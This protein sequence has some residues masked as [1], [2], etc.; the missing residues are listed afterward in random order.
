M[1]FD[2]EEIKFSRN[3]PDDTPPDG[4]TDCT[5]MNNTLLQLVE[6][7][8]AVDCSIPN[9]EIEFC[10]AVSNI[11]YQD[12]SQ[13]TEDNAIALLVAQVFVISTVLKAFDEE[14]KLDFLEHLEIMY[15][16]AEDTFFAPQDTCDRG[17]D[18]IDIQEMNQKLLEILREC[19]FNDSGSRLEMMLH[20][21]NLAA[22]ED[23]GTDELLHAELMALLNFTIISLLKGIDDESRIKIIE[24]IREAALELARE[25]W[26]PYHDS[27]SFI[28]EEDSGEESAPMA[29]RVTFSMCFDSATMDGAIATFVK[30]A[31]SI[32]APENLD[33]VLKVETF[34]EPLNHPYVNRKSV[35]TRFFDVDNN[36]AVLREVLNLRED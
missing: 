2:E 15:A 4:L 34:E 19:D 14:S 6:L 18:P 12:G 27:P 35:K 9:V 30:S 36:K 31:E 8:D 32:L 22:V 10:S 7:V 11:L 1:Y 26:V 28:A 20:T 21:M 3:I 25:V 23:G 29:R 16:F 17:D 13:L 24:I 33:A 5:D